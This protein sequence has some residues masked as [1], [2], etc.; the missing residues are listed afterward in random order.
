MT[1]GALEITC[2]QY[3]IFLSFFAICP[4]LMTTITVMMVDSDEDSLPERKV[5]TE[6]MKVSDCKIARYRTCTAHAE[7]ELSAQH[8]MVTR[9]SGE[10]FRNIYSSYGNVSTPGVSPVSHGFLAVCQKYT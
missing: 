10:N 7:Q 9:N 5:H 1:T 3:E 6:H 8:I 2:L 4:S